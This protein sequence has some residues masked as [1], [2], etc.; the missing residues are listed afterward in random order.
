MLDN[1]ELT[2][3]R[4]QTSQGEDDRFGKY[5]ATTLTWAHKS[6]DTIDAVFK[7]YAANRS[8]I[9]FEQTF[10]REIVG[11]PSLLVLP[12]RR[13]QARSVFP[14]F[15]R[16]ISDH[17]PCFSYDGVFPSMKS[18][19]VAKYR[20]TA[21]GGTPLVIYDN[22]D[23][24][25]PMTVFS[26][27]GNPK[28][29]HMY[30][31]LDRFGAGVKGTATNIPAGFTLRFILSAAYGINDGMKQW[32]DHLL[33]ALGQTREDNRYRDDVHAGLGFWTDNGGY[34]HYSLGNNKSL[35]DNYEEVLTSVHEYH[36]QVGIPFRH[37]QFDSWFYPK[38]GKVG[39]MG[40]GGGVTKYVLYICST[41]ARE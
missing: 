13:R 36:Q 32:G 18:S 35:G 28:A 21:Q 24:R 11:A 26:P 9:V 17:R 30:S 25:L 10:L 38:D 6:Q 2:L 14:S 16:S 22:S 41:D 33:K 23:P 4:S 7:T 20:T 19:T 29:Q 5:N 31:S 40:G 15:E 39:P 34:Y 8:I 37:W 27:L 1:R 3:S 12:E